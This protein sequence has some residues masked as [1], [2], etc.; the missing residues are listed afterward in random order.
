MTE[1]QM[2]SMITRV[3]NKYSVNLSAQ[4]IQSLI[5]GIKVKAAQQGTLQLSFNIGKTFSAQHFSSSNIAQFGYK[6]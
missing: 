2:L 3:S 5:E 4:Q 6:S 1:E